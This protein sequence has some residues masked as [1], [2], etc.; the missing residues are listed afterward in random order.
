MVPMVGF[1]PTNLLGWQF[2]ELLCL[3]N[4]TTRAVYALCIAQGACYKI[5]MEAAY[6]CPFLMVAL[7]AVRFHLAMRRAVTIL[8]K[9]STIKLPISCEL[10][11]FY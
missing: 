2:P 4:S 11:F 10:S 7:V 3:L 9:F 5:I 1:A 6:F 8:K